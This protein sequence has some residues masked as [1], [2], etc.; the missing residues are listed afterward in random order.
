[1]NDQLLPRPHNV[2]LAN[3]HRRIAAANGDNLLALL[4]ENAILLR[5]DCGGRGLCGK[6]RIETIAS[7]GQRR[8]T[9][10][11]TCRVESDLTIAIP[12][13]SRMSA[14]IV[15]KAE[16]RLPAGFVGK[17][18]LEKQG[19][20]FGIAVDLGTTT[21]AAYLVDRYDRRVLASLA[22][23]N[24]QSLFGDD[25]MSRIAS[26][27]DS[28]ERLQRLQRLTSGAI[29]W[30]TEALT[31]N[32][33]ELLGRP[34]PMVVVGN[35]TMIHLLLGVS[36]AS[37]G[38][39][40]Y[41]PGFYQARDSEGAALGLSSRATTVR[42]LPQVSGF[43][44]GDILAAAVA[45]DLPR[46]PPG[47]LLVDLG[48]NGEL[49]LKGEERLY[50]TSCATGPAFEGA[51]ISCGMQA[52][53]GAIDRIAVDRQLRPSYRTITGKNRAMADKPLGICGS[54]VIS[55]V[56]AMLT[57][58]VIEKSGLL[59]SDLPPDLVDEEAGV[60]RYL[61]AKDG[62]EGKVAI[63]QKD[64]RQV[65]LGKAA[66]ISGI[67][68]LLAAAGIKAPTQ[69]LVAGA[70][71]SHLEKHDLLTLG[72]LPPLDPEQIT[73]VGN[74]AGGGAIMVLCDDRHLHSAEKMAGQ[75]TVLNLAADPEFQ[76]HFIN[77]LSF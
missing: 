50:A 42:T 12:E 51:T 59:A 6:C 43:I 40:P 33:R 27:G 11:C 63:S 72:M 34:A 24:P 76:E 74:A 31:A 30:A 54:G 49:L 28:G 73:M 16:V 62:A 64:I 35:P 69:L 13:S 39:S 17:K 4:G 3:D 47:T 75:I 25:V 67:E 20:R 61:I 48:T 45:V 1:M 15:D 19:E 57:A 46:Q 68:F 53:P 37:I 32:R 66:L 8:S 70:F 18:P 7:D 38:L 60:R 14:D 9:T 5:A 55:G 36:P 56:A 41:A 58:G 23:K 52:L 29:G 21:I 22:V 26:I 10:A 77:R 44:G 71:G 2:V 65:Q